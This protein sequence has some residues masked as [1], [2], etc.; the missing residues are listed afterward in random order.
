M[1]DENVF[2]ASRV[3]E[4]RL[5]S[6]GVDCIVRCQD[7]GSSSGSQRY[8]FR[9]DVG[10]VGGGRAS[11]KDLWGGPRQLMSMRTCMDDAEA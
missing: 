3:G 9:I 1:I 7:E 11:Y 5:A 10:P 2:A 4:D 8:A 6:W